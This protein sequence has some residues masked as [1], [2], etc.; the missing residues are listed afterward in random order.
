MPL[1][2]ESELASS[3]FVRDLTSFFGQKPEVLRAIAEVGDDPDGFLGGSQARRVGS[4]C[5]IS[6]SQALNCLRIAAYLYDRVSE[7]GMGVDEAVAQLRSVAGELEPVPAIDEEKL[8]AISGVLEFKRKYEVSRAV[9]QATSNA[10]HF[11]NANGSW[12][13]RPV[14][15]RSGEVVNVPVV[16]L[17]IHWHD[18]AGNSHDT[19]L[20]MSQDEW[21]SFCNEVETITG[22][23][24]DVEPLL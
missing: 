3:A 7:L 8:E 6:S 20:Q 24:G 21:S 16:A 23:F 22:H 1:I 2:R 10:P 9:T 17:S 12:S 18:G 13:V 5:E 14:R 15:I 11:V 19:F 4:K